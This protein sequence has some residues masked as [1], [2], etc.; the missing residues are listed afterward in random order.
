MR[1][2]ASGR[3]WRELAIGFGLALAWLAVIPCTS[4]AHAQTASP[5]PGAAPFPAPLYDPSLRD[6]NYYRYTRVAASGA[7]RG[8]ELYYFKCWQCHNEFQTTAPQLK[9]LYQNGTLISGAPVNDFTL[10]ERIKNGGEGMPSF[11]FELSDTDV[12][13][14]VAFV[15]D[16][17]CWDPENPPPNP[18]YHAA[19]VPTLE[20]GKDNVRGGPWGFVRSQAAPSRSV[21]TADQGAAVSTPLEGIMVQLRGTQ[22]N[23]TTTVYSD[24]TGRFEFPKL[25]PG[26][27]SLRIARAL[28]FK[29]FYK[30]SITIDGAA[31]KLD[32]IVLERVSAGEFVPPNWDTAAQLSGA[33]LVWNVNGTAEEKRTFSYACGSGCHT[34]GQILR[35]RFD[36][37]SWR[38]IVTKMTHNT[39]SLL[40][41]EARPNRVPP[42]E[43][44]VIVKWLT[45]VRGPNSKDM[46]YQ[47]F[48]A[49][50]GA[51]TKVVVTEYELPRLLTAPHDP[52]G[53]ARGNI[54]YNSHRTAWLSK[55]DPATGT[56]E[57]FKVPSTRGANP[58]QHWLTVDERDTIWFSE[59]WSHKL[60]R[61]DPKTEKF[62]HVQL[63]HFRRAL[64]AP[65][66]GNLALAPDH[67]IWEARDGAVHRLDPIT[68]QVTQEFKLAKARG[69][70]GNELSRDGRYYAGGGWPEDWVIFADTKTGEVTEL[71]TRTPR[72]GPKRGGFDPDGNAWFGGTG[73]LLIK[74]D[75]KTKQ[76]SEFRPPTPNVT[77]YECM[78]DKNGEIWAGEL[79]AGRVVRYNPKTDR[80]TEYV[81]PSPVSHDRRTWIDNSTTPVS[82][83]YVD[84]DSIMVRLQPLE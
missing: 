51:A 61:F 21:R 69:A 47:L 64:N 34:Y 63:P 65:A 82:V 56:V 30:A 74:F 33:E 71:Q 45:K 48:P 39:G 53:D 14:L 31:P 3:G 76:L 9:G 60:G 44:D 66:A 49:P 32:D 50:H 5:T 16:K 62:E 54:W 23:I 41:Q 84:H 73:G 4:A 58:G 67:S 68:G 19:P 17:C 22:S 40:L 43:Q 36:E 29:P 10:S 27:Y 6:L 57:D 75:A 7:E 8:R 20:P 11:R 37:R 18:Q 70:Y 26:T 42:A 77:F 35:N 12:A 13:D 59:N 25:K 78:P 52:V 80:W 79:Y 2:L 46:G 55:L 38:L 81:L 72:A 15:R 24:D 28:E 1:V 83:W